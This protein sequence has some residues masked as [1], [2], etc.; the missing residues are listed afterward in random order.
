MPSSL[1]VFGTFGYVRCICCRHWSQGS[2]AGICFMAM[3]LN[4]L[5]HCYLLFAEN[6]NKIGFVDCME[7]IFMEKYFIK[8]TEETSGCYRFLLLSRRLHISSKQQFRH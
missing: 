8:K 3:H 1:L 7:S 2:G 6:V 5:H 4:R